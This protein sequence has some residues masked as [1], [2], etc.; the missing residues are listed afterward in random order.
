MKRNTLPNTDMQNKALNLVSPPLMMIK[1]ITFFIMFNYLLSF[2]FCS[3]SAVPSKA[4][5][6]TL[7]HQYC[8]T[9][10]R[11]LCNFF[12][13]KFKGYA[14]LSNKHKTKKCLSSFHWSSFHGFVGCKC[15]QFGAISR[16]FLV[17]EVTI[18]GVKTCSCRN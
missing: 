16:A 11:G 5:V 18:L 9:K 7:Q 15:P 10:T 8:F 13:L 17:S 14:Y 2:D 1:K 3:T 12:S 4:P 6:C